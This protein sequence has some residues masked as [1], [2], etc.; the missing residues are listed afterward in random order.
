MEKDGPGR[1]NG[2]S[3]PDE[4]DWPHELVMLYE[5]ETSDLDELETSDLDELETNGLDELETSDLDEQE[6]KWIGWS[7]N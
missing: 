1:K 2:K 7:R 5:L 6:T 3:T 4:L